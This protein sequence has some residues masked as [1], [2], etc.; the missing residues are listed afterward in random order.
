[1]SKAVPK[2]TS[3][4][5]CRCIG[6]LEI[7]NPACPVHGHEAMRALAADLTKVVE[8]FMPNV[9]RC[10]LQDYARLNDAMFRARCAGLTT[11]K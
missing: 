9:G 6:S 3:V 7:E 10:V 8:D 1:M 4:A 11:A 2:I 5:D